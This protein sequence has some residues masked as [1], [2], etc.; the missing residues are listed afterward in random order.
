MFKIIIIL[1]SIFLIENQAEAACGFNCLK[2][3]GEKILRDPAG[4][5]ADFE[6][7][8][9]K[10]IENLGEA[11]KREYDNLVES[12]EKTEIRIPVLESA[13]TNITT[14]IRKL[15]GKKVSAEKVT[16]DLVETKNKAIASKNT[17]LNTTSETF[18]KTRSGL[19]GSLNEV[20][21]NITAVTK[22]VTQLVPVYNEYTNA[23][24]AINKLKQDML[25]ARAESVDNILANVTYL[26]GY[27]S[28][29]QDYF[30]SK[31][32]AWQ[33]WFNS[34][35]DVTKSWISVQSDS[36]LNTLAS[37]PGDFQDWFVEQT[38]SFKDLV[39]FNPD[40]LSW[41]SDSLKTFASFS[42]EDAQFIIDNR[43][44]L[45]AVSIHD[46]NDYM[47]HIGNIIA[48]N[49][50]E[51][52]EIISQE[53]KSCV[54]NGGCDLVKHCL[55]TRVLCR[56]VPGYSSARA[57]ALHYVE[58]R[59]NLLKLMTSKLQNAREKVKAE[60]LSGLFLTDDDSEPATTTI[61]NGDGG[62]LKTITDNKGNTGFIVTSSDGETTIIG[63]DSEGDIKGIRTI[64]AST[65]TY[66]ESSPI[67]SKS[68]DQIANDFEYS[69]PP[70]EPP[71]TDQSTTSNDPQGSDG[72][73]EPSGGFDP[74]AF[75]GN[76]A[77][78]EEVFT[79]P[80]VNLEN[81]LDDG[82]LLPQTNLGYS[83]FSEFENNNPEPTSGSST[84]GAQ[85]DQWAKS[86]QR[87]EKLRDFEKE[88][89]EHLKNTYDNS[90]WA[91]EDPSLYEMNARD[92]MDGGA[93]DSIAPKNVRDVIAADI[94]YG[95]EL[96]K[97]Q[98]KIERDEL[99]SDYQER[100][101]DVIAAQRMAKVEGGNVE[102]STLDIHAEG[103]SLLDL[104]KFAIDDNDLAFATDALKASRDVL[105]FVA[106]IGV[107]FIPGV[108]NVRAAAELAAGK[109]LI[110]GEDYDNWD[111]A[112]GAVG[113]ILPIAG[114]AGKAF[115]AY[116]KAADKLQNADHISDATKTLVKKNTDKLDEAENALANAADCL[117]LNLTCSG[118]DIFKGA[119]LDEVI[120]TANKI[121]IS[122]TSKVIQL[123]ETTSQTGTEV[124]SGV[125]KSE[126][127]KRAVKATPA[128]KLMF[129]RSSVGEAIPSTGYRYVPSSAA[130]L[131]E[132]VSTGR[133]PARSPTAIDPYKATYFGFDKFDDAATAS[134]KFQVPHDAAIRVEFDTLQIVD[135]VRIPN[136]KWNTE[137]YLEPI[138]KDY[139]EHG[140]GGAAQAVTNSEIRASKIVDLN[141]GEVL[142]ERK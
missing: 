64:P 141:T 65:P 110:T 83:N 119:K 99:V 42:I 104:A 126:S 118:G 114:K 81:L 48:V 123:A 29:F 14:K 68:I 97:D 100:H 139:P 63:V 30:H 52:G 112:F 125:R 136:G 56:V 50:Q 70:I 21:Q 85:G 95:R 86:L 91:K 57:E 71:S 60:I 122:D 6:E 93:F 107:D 54:L 79:G 36:F 20:T 2:K 134:S 67:E 127:F 130:Y 87:M 96:L 73:S 105:E 49:G 74:N 133:I 115:K 32:K 69:I 41:D 106:D 117:T 34:K 28:S 18:E 90:N 138:T 13:I 19:E 17:I 80:V 101:A 38:P 45:S 58:K 7:Q 33:D 84:S 31:D 98:L 77:P 75:Y 8:R 1:F 37:T 47:A 62:S 59:Q 121:G 116:F 43:S 111:Y 124:L 11:A 66:E 137:K 128:D 16:Q 120:E 23:E 76:Y 88:R 53:F 89:Y 5:L 135:D 4:A 92:F 24:K 10:D 9:R 109:N 15:A 51:A 82:H 40:L 102:V 55:E 72:D 27:A 142:Y 26:K 35:N 131:D 108:G 129:Y 44:Y 113:I 46:L 22:Q 61:T 25:N 103:E 94:N 12:I 78:P 132:L 140:V 3:S 39:V